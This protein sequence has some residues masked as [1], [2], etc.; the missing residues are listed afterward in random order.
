[1]F[2]VLGTILF[3]GLR[4]TIRF[5]LSPGRRIGFVTFLVGVALVLAGWPITGFLTELF[6]FINLYGYGQWGDVADTGSRSHMHIDIMTAAWYG[7]VLRLF[8]TTVFSTATCTDA[9]SAAH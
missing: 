5:G 3:S 1:M 8:L 6:G 7:I 2:L 4:P 9:P